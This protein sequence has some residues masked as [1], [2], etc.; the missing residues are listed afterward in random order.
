MVTTAGAHYCPAPNWHLLMDYFLKK[1]P[2]NL[3]HKKQCSSL[4][5]FSNN[6]AIPLIFKKH[7]EINRQHYWMLLED[8]TH[9]NAF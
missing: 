7:K 3:Y 5:L 4:L 2:L 9:N 6:K 8:T 1:P